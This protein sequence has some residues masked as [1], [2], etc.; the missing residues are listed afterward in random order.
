MEDRLMPNTLEKTLNWL[1]FVILLLVIVMLA[2]PIF[3]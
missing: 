2:E 1:A 3:L